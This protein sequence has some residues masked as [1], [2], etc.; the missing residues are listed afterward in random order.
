MSI[1][2]EEEIIDMNHN[3]NHLAI[4]LEKIDT[5]FAFKM[6]EFSELEKSEQAH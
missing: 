5:V 2:N 4:L 1:T 6:S 3:N